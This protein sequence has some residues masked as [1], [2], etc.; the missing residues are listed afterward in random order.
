VRIRF[1]YG[2]SAL[3][4]IPAFLLAAFLLVTLCCI[5]I[6]AWLHGFSPSV[7]SIALIVFVGGFVFTT[8]YRFFDR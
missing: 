6:R 7:L 3:P 2:P 4:A 5:E 1:V 8:G